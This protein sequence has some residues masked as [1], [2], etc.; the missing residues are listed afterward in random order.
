MY[1]FFLLGNWFDLQLACS[2]L[3]PGFAE[4]AIH[5]TVYTDNMAM[6]AHNAELYSFVLVNLDFGKALS[7]CSQKTESSAIKLQK[8]C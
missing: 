7:A 1:P 2:G 6:H 3:E 5:S 4:Y 8:K